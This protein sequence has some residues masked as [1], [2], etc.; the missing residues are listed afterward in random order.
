M[1]RHFGL[2]APAGLLLAAVV[3]P[4]QAQGSGDHAC[5]AGRV[6][7]IFID[8]HSIFD[9]SDPDLDPRFRWAYTLANRLH[10]RTSE[11]VIRREL[12]FDVGDCFDPIRLEESERLLRGYPFIARADIYAIQ[13]PGGAYHVVVDTEDEWSTQLETRLDLSQGLDF[14]GADLREQNFLGTG[15]EVEAFYSNLNATRTYGLRYFSPQLFRSRWDLEMSGGRTRAGTLLEQTVSYPFVGEI[16]RWAAQQRFYRQDRFFDYLLPTQAG[17]DTRLLIPLREKEFQVAALRR[18]GRLGNLTI[19]GGG[20]GFQEISYP[21]SDGSL[22]LVRNNDYG[23]TSPAP[24]A[25]AEP[26][27]GS[28]EHRRN[29]RAMVFLGKRNIVW[30]QREGLDSFHGEQDLRTGTDVEMSFARSLPALES[31][32]DL[33]ASIDFYAATGPAT[34]FFATRMRADGRRDYDAEPGI[35]E[36]KDVIAEGEWFLY[37]RP[38]FESHHTLLLRASAA[39]GWHTSTPFQITLGGQQSLRGFPQTAF[40]GGRRLVFTA[41]DRFYLGWPFPDVAD[42]GTSLFVDVGRIWPGDAPYGQSSGWRT[43][44]G[45][46]IRANFPAGGTNT[47]RVDAAFPV[48]SDG[49]LGKL[50]LLIGVTEYLGITS[51]FTDPQLSRSRVPPITGNLLN[52]PN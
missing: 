3:A 9:T 38:A 2:S 47:F 41:E 37:V 32:D 42:I 26:A 48:G 1:R 16:G 44:I 31:D 17:E 25:V 21:G 12:L 10:V 13:Q 45:G 29:I 35:Y 50:Q 34:A 43:S 15:R 24:P 39:G 49:G 19:V 28:M 52:F 6:E 11:S 20:V 33:H 4:L 27:L 40:P 22:E 7:H 46:G 18:F 14:Q 5:K 51:G 36:M 8:N 23:H 30:R